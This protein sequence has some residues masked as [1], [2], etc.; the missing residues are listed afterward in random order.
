MSETRT[1]AAFILTHGRPDNVLTYN[2]LRK[3]GYTGRII[4]IVD[5]EDATLP[6]YISRY[7]KEVVTFSKREIAKTFDIMDNMRSFA[8][9][10]YARNASWDIA[11]ERNIT[12]FIQLDDDY[13]YFQFKRDDTF[14]Y[15]D[16]WIHS[17]LD[18]VFSAMCT[19]LDNTSVL[20]ICMAQ[21]GDFTGGK[22]NRQ[23]GNKNGIKLLRKAMN[24]F[25]VRTDRPFVFHGR[26]NDD[27]NT[28]TY[29]G[30]IGKL[31]TTTS[32]VMIRQCATQMNSGG[33]TKMY[34]DSGTFVKSFYTTMIC[35]SS[36][37]V[38][39]TH[40]MNRIH[41]RVTWRATC[42]MIL[43]EQLGKGHS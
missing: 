37:S 41:H 17:A 23:L 30:S 11:R 42:P 14:G 6:A 5:D 19:F 22:Q 43:R 8:S 21:G 16:K 4:L 15:E 32:Q 20:T 35:P 9:V 31:L 7:G 40:S 27:V 28:Y 26:M 12:H 36:V 1:F 24:S 39:Y 10:V 2:A 25:V 29:L 13:L 3:S 33:L 38:T 34:H 18:E